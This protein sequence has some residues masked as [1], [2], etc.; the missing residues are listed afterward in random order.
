M[1]SFRARVSILA[2]FSSLLVPAS[3]STK[4]K[5]L[6][7]SAYRRYFWGARNAFDRRQFDQAA[8]LLETYQSLGE[9]RDKLVTQSGCE[10]PDEVK[11]FAARLRAVRQC[12]A[13]KKKD[14][15][16][17]SDFEKAKFEITLALRDGMPDPLLGFVGCAPVD[18]TFQVDYC[19][20]SNTTTPEALALLV[21]KVQGSPNIF[22]HLVW[23]ESHVAPQD[24]VSP[25]WTLYS[26]SEQWAP[27]GLPNAPLMTLREDHHHHIRI[28]GFAATGF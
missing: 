27:K 26:S 5:P 9:P 15:H 1:I 16:Y 8:S 19:P 10:S 2:A 25:R 14:D 24:E 20:A 23:R 4:G 28:A 6:Q 7:T 17:W 13:K 22:S 11:R 12:I 3:A 18:L 21:A